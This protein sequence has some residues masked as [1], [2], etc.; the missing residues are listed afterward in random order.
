MVF[1]FGY[2]DNVGST[3]NLLKIHTE[4][5]NEKTKKLTDERIKI[6]TYNRHRDKIN[7]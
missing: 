1:R 6:H 2:I 3:E 5:E 4:N 7:G